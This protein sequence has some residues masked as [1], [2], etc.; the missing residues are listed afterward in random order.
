MRG[1][2]IFIIITNVHYIFLLTIIDFPFVLPWQ[3]FY[4]IIYLFDDFSFEI[5][6]PSTFER[7]YENNFKMRK[8]R[9]QVDIMANQNLILDLLSCHSDFKYKTFKLFCFIYVTIK[10]EYIPISNSLLF[11]MVKVITVIYF[12]IC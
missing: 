3:P 5:K 2:Q 12:F 6:L 10:I 8:D 9:L 7:I 1:D 4:F 11:N